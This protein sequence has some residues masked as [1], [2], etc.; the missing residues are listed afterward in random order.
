MVWHSQLLQCFRAGYTRLQDYT[1]KSY[2]KSI[3]TQVARK[4]A[5]A[6]YGNNQIHTA[7]WLLYFPGMTYIYRE[8]C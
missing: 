4:E 5:I 1:S 6:I 7:L 8:L 3:W 2:I